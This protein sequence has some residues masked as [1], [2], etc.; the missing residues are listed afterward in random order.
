MAD[1]HDL[2][3][4]SSAIEAQRRLVQGLQLAV[5]SQVDPAADPDL[6]SRLN[7]AHME[8]SALEKPVA[9]ESDPTVDRRDGLNGARFLGAETTGLKVDVKV[10][11]EPVPTGAYHLMDQDKDPLVS[12]QIENVSGDIRRIC[13]QAFIEGLS[14]KAVRTGEIKPAKTETLNLLPTL[15]SDRAKSITEV[16]RAT[17]HVIVD[18]LDGKL[19]SHNT[20][21]ITCLS[22]A[23]S[24]NSVRG[25]DGEPRDLSHYYGAWVTPY[26]ESVQKR[27]REAVAKMSDSRMLGYQGDPRPQV[28]ALYQSLREAE[29]LYVN[30]VI[31]YGSANGLSTQRTRLPSESLSDR[32]AN[33]IDGTVLLASLIE[34]ISLNPAILL[35]PGHALVGWEKGPGANEFQFLETTMIGSA[36]FDAAADSGQ[37][38]YEEMLKY[39]QDGFKLHSV[40][41]L[42]AQGIWPME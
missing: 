14:A 22:R 30:S 38:Q 15:F 8:L 32:Q 24:F 20:Y 42:R 26:V 25:P 23:A 17:L 7:A 21:I 4:T 36:E 29:I 5:Y 27:I 28:A 39:N 6:L 31:D 33:C 12:V 16:Q 2:E 35:V 11:M 1:Q 9:P 18:D 3:A 41:A 19:E 40:G 13:V 34:G 37:R 10:C